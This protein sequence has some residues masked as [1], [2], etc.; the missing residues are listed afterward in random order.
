MKQRFSGFR[1]V[2]YLI[3]F[4]CLLLLRL[5]PMPDGAGGMLAWSGCVALAATG[6]LIWYAASEGYLRHLGGGIMI[7]LAIA[8]VVA[9]CP[10]F[11]L[12][13]MFWSVSGLVKRRRALLTQALASIA[14]FFLVFPMPLARLA[15]MPELAGAPAGIAY[16]MFAL[17]YSAWASRS[18]LK[19]GLFRFATMLVAV[20]L[21]ASFVALV[22][23]GM[24]G[25]PQRRTRNTI[26]DRRIANLPL[27]APVRIDPV[28]PPGVPMPLAMPTPVIAGAPAI[29]AMAE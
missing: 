13:L 22:G 11:V 14:L 7:Y 6:Y 5:V 19:V 2:V 16:V 10:P 26:R 23:G 17:A 29:V 28:T 21:I 25:R 3:G 4:T 24:L 27:P 1:F 18:P 15:G 8:A 12:L 9:A 20:P